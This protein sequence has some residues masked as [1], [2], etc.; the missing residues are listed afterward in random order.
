MLLDALDHHYSKPVYNLIKSL[1]DGAP[2]ETALSDLV[3]VGHSSGSDIL[4]GIYY[5]LSSLSQRLL[6]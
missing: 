3:T 4:A 1:S 6:T 5:S 2:T